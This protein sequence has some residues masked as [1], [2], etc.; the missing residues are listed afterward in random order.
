LE[1]KDRAESPTPDD[2]LGANEMRPFNSS[3][4]FRLEAH[5]KMDQ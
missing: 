2:A 1:A 4:F 5:P 3:V